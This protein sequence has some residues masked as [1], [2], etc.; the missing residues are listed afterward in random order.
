[1]FKKPVSLS[2]GKALACGSNAPGEECATA[3]AA[4]FFHVAT[5]TKAESCLK[6]L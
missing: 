2:V 1:M 5:L 3:T 6:D 4:I